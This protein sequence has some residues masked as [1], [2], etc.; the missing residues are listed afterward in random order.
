M[1]YALRQAAQFG[2]KEPETGSDLRIAPDAV[3]KELDGLFDASHG[4]CASL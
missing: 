3:K 1:L 2:H 4:A